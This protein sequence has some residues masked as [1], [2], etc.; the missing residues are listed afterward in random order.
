MRACFWP[1]ALTAPWG[2]LCP[3]P[4]LEHSW[5]SARGRW[6]RG[7][8]F[9]LTFGLETNAPYTLPHSIFW[10]GHRWPPPS[11]ASTPSS[12]AASGDRPPQVQAL[13]MKGL[14]LDASPKTYGWEYMEISGTLAKS[15]AAHPPLCTNW[16]T[17]THSE[18]PCGAATWKH[19]CR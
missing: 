13:S 12:S 19:M 1:H 5:A 3:C 11:P 16:V 8:P 18:S 17:W 10:Y 14:Y 9:P 4:P 15:R 7:S 2:S 6:E